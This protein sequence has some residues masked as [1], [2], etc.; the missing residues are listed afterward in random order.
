MLALAFDQ[1]DKPDAAFSVPL[2]FEL[3]GHP[4]LNL[5]FPLSPVAPEMPAE[6]SAE[7]TANKSKF[8]ISAKVTRL[9]QGLPGGETPQANPS[10]PY[11]DFAYKYNDYG[12]NPNPDPLAP[13]LIPIATDVA[14]YTCPDNF[15]EIHVKVN[16]KSGDVPREFNLTSFRANLVL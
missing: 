15:L 4:D 12:P 11:L 3:P 13:P 14:T 10:P 9:F 6:G 16:F 2:H 8:T 7:I 5:D 1:L